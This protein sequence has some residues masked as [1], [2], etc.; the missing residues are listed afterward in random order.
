MDSGYKR[1]AELENFEAAYQLQIE[2]ALEATRQ[3]AARKVEVV[4]ID[5]DEAEQQTK[6]PKKN[7]RPSSTSTYRVATAKSGRKRREAIEV[8]SDDEMP[9]HK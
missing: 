5:D 2:E 3:T 6:R 9:D 8:E 4:V 7:A 1:K